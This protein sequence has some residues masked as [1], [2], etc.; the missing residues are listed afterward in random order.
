MVV[1]DSMTLDESE[2][3]T[4]AYIKELSKKHFS[5]EALVNR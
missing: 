5:K 3:T 2:S 4:I 1:Q